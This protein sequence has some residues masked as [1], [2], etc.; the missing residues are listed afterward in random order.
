MTSPTSPTPPTS[1]VGE[2]AGHEQ[3]GPAKRPLTPLAG[4]Y[5]HPFHPI[6]VT[7]PIGAWTLSLVFDL[8]SRWSGEPEVFVKASFW[9]IG[10]GILAALLAAV[11]GLLD[12]LTIPRGTPAFTTGLT[13]L[14]LNLAVVVLYAI[15][16]ALRRDNLDEADVTVPA[17]V[18]SAV[19]YALLGVSGWLGG[20]LAYH[21]GVRVADEGTQASGFVRRH[22]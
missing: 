8:V 19:A 12:L 2:Y 20:K 1:P 14:A 3:P 11:F 9:L 16:F 17:F 4:P 18:V 22:D 7:V 21:Y 13:H 6:L 15:S 5:G 10:A